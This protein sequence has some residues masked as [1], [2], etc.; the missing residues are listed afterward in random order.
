[1]YHFL[2]LE[3]GEEIM[4]GFRDDADIGTLAEHCVG[5]TAAGLTVG[6]DCAIIA[7]DETGDQLFRGLGVDGVLRGFR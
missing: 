4:D 7:V 6:D 1:M 5:F 2:G 3:L